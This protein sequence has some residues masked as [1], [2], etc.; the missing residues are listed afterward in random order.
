MI[1]KK[2]SLGEE[3]PY[4]FQ[5]WNLKPLLLTGEVC[6]IGSTIYS[7][8]IRVQA[9]EFVTPSFVTHP[10]LHLTPQFSILVHRR[11]FCYPRYKQLNHYCWHSSLLSI[12]LLYKLFQIVALFELS[13]LLTL[14]TLFIFTVPFCS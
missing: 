11:P 2:A 5:D 4:S 8:H 9:F 1:L 10:F 6:L 12:I 3:D 13:S 7:F 14:D